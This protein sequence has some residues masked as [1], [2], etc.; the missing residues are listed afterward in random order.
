MSLDMECMCLKCGISVYVD[1]TGIS[2]EDLGQGEHKVIR[3][4]FCTEC[5][6]HL[7]LIGRAGDEPHYKIQT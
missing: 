5:G 6:G 3:N 2:L 4:V 1:L 7:A